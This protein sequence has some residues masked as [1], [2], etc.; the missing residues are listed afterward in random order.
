MSVDKRMTLKEAV[1][2]FIL[3]GDTLYYG[4]FQIMVPMALTYEII[5]Q[6]KKHL[7][8]L[9]TSTDA[10]G[11]DLLVAAGCIDEMHLAWAMNWCARA[12]HAIQ[13]AFQDGELKRHD[14]SNFGA[15]GALMAGYLGVPFFPVRGNIGTDVVKYNSADV[16]IIDDPFTG[17]PITVVRAWRADVALIHAQ[18]ADHL[19]NVVAWGTHGNGDQHGAMGS[20]RGV[21]VTAEEIV[22]PEMVR[23]DPDRTLIPYYKTLA[24]VPCPWGAHPSACRGFYGLDVRFAQY[25]GKYMKKK[26]IVPHFLNEWIYGVKDHKAYI[27]KYVNTFGQEAL[28]RLKPILGFKPQMEVDYGY[29][30]PNIWEGVPP[31]TDMHIR[32]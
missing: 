16:R 2:K 3:E 14:I 5:R 29:H 30:D 32:G 17:K 10:G 15:T 9:S 24:V 22:D 19:G 6:R 13:R 7:N 23:S 28:E 11:L 27:Q 21:I 8:I 4:G 26:E 20:K 12:P 31:Y 25:Q 18:R 1:S